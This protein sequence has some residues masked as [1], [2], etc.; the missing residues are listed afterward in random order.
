M[1]ELDVV[2]VSVVLLLDDLAERNVVHDTVLALNALQLDRCNL[3]YQK[4]SNNFPIY[5][6]RKGT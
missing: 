3:E 1:A 4:N 2:C 5:R 6:I